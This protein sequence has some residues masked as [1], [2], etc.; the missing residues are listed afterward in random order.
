[1]KN[2]AKLLDLVRRIREL[3][4]LELQQN[5]NRKLLIK[6]NHFIHMVEEV[7]ETTKALRGKNDEPLEDEAMDTVICALALALLEV[8]GNIDSLMVIMEKKL[9]KWQR[10]LEEKT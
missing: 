4:E 8:D 7:G 2:P 9:D 1:M 5:D 6:L 3:N 10:R